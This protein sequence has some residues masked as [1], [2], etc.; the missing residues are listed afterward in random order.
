MVSIKKYSYKMLNSGGSLCVRWK[1]K[2]KEKKKNHDKISSFIECNCIN[3]QCSSGIHGD[4]SCDCDSG[5]NGTSCDQGTILS[6]IVQ[7]VK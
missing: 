3:G 2:R 7:S 1:K 5:Y 6:I 4:G